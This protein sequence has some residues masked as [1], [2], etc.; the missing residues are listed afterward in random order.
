VPAIVLC[1]LPG[2]AM[3]NGRSENTLIW[4]S[5]LSVAF[6]I[7]IPTDSVNTKS[8]A[9][10]DNINLWLLLSIKAPYNTSSYK[11]KYLSQR[12]NEINFE[13]PF[14]ILRLENVSKIWMNLI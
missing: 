5:G 14:N 8:T 11:F 6:A 4:T 12:K 2:D 9:S 7:T 10:E 1:E 3:L 13:L